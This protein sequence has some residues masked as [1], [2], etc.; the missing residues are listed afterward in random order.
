MALVLVG[1]GPGHQH[2]VV[3]LA[4]VDGEIAA[5]QGHRHLAA[6]AADPGGRD[7]GGAGRR[8]A[9][10]GEAG[11]ALPGADYY[12]IARWGRCERDIGA[13]WKDR[14]V[15]E[16][17]AD[18]G[19][20]E[21]LRILDPE[22]RMRIAHADDRRRLQA[23]HIRNL[24]ID[25][26]RIGHVVQQR[27]LIPAKAR[28]AHVD[29][30]QPAIRPPTGNE[31]GRR[32][33]F[34]HRLAG[35]GADQR[36]HAAHAVAAS[37]GLRA[38]VVEDADGGVGSAIRRIERHELVVR[39][40]LCRRARFGRRNRARRAAQVD[41]DDLVAETVHLDEIP[42]RQRAHDNARMSGTY[43]RTQGP[44]ASVRLRL[45]S[46]VT[47]LDAVLASVLEFRR[48]DRIKKAATAIAGSAGPPG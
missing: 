9:G 28:P 2:M 32:L 44:S 18:A 17:R 31:P 43:M 20:V 4:P 11:A 8:A 45:T 38:V 41:D 23:R 42:V 19:E 13:L 15:L 37:A 10:L 29:R 40:A 34:Q 1:G 6:G 33:E 12:T 16:P 47:K 46:T 22:N 25:R 27:N 3:G 14:V 48:G 30:E 7:R 26:A 5:R 39:L 35:F 21:T 24:E 36:R